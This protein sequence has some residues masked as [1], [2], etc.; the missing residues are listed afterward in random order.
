MSRMWK[1]QSFCK[2]VYDERPDKNKNKSIKKCWQRWEWFWRWHIGTILRINSNT[3][4]EQIYKAWYVNGHLNGVDVKFKLITHTSYYTP[5]LYVQP[6]KC[7]SFHVRLCSH[8][9]SVND[10]A[11]W[12][13]D[14]HQTSITDTTWKYLGVKF[15]PWG[16]L[17]W[18]WLLTVGA[19]KLGNPILNPLRGWSCLI[20]MPFYGCSSKLTIVSQ[21]QCTP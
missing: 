8:S 17:T 7:C 5:G 1:E 13:L 9:F 2:D 16:G 15:S 21:Q 14:Q 10:C 19:G 20:S 11:P 3:S 6:R 18:Q 4:V 12:V